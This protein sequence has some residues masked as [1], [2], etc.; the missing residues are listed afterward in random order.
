MMYASGARTSIKMKK[1]AKPV[2][3]SP[4]AIVSFFILQYSKAMRN[5]LE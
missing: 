3:L 2:S 1:R 4:L 5:L